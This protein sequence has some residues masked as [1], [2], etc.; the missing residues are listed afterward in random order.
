MLKFLI[1]SGKLKLEILVIKC[2]FFFCVFCFKSCIGLKLYEIRVVNNVSEFDGSYI[3]LCYLLCG[4]C[5]M[6]MKSVMLE[7]VFVMDKNENFFVVKMLN[8]EDI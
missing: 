5:V 3:S 1:E 8:K 6:E 7:Y 2:K 4:L